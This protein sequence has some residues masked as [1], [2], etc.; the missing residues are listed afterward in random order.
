[1]TS[2]TIRPEK[3]RG[4]PYGIRSDLR[5]MVLDMW[6]LPADPPLTAAQ[7]AKYVNS[8]AGTNYKPRTINRVIYWARIYK[9]PRA[10][11]HNGA[12]EKEIAPQVLDQMRAEIASG[13]LTGIT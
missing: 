1:M 3:R 11:Y 7:I 9:D 6:A 2:A 8:K 5:D 4:Q 10:I 13:K 12:Q